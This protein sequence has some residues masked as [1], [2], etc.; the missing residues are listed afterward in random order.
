VPEVATCS[1][2]S[3]SA[4]L[5]RQGRVGAHKA[6]QMGRY[7]VRGAVWVRAE[8][9]RWRASV[10]REAAAACVWMDALVLETRS[11]TPV[12]SLMRRTEHSTIKK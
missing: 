12:S 3:T 8:E 5:Q 1:S 7:S 10:G 6:M 11:L 2:Y 9:K 4:H